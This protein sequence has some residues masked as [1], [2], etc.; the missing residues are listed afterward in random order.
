MI[1]RPDRAVFLLYLPFFAIVFA[2]ALYARLPADPA[3]YLW[4]DESWRAY[5]ILSTGDF[6][7][8]LRFMRED[9]HFPLFSEWLFG[10]IGLAIFGFDEFAFR[11]WPLIFSLLSIAGA[12][13]FLIR[14]GTVSGALAA[15]FFIS[16]GWGFIFHAREFKPFALD[17]ALTAWSFFAA[18][19][20][21][22]KPSP[23]RLALLAGTLLAASLCS[24]VFVFI[25]PAVLAYLPYR[26]RGLYRQREERFA[27]A[28]LLVP[29]CVFV[30]IYLLVYAGGATGPTR[31][32]WADFYLWPPENI[33]FILKAGVQSSMGYF[34]FAWPAVPICYVYCAIISWRRKDG[35]WLLLMTPLLFAAIASALRLYPLFGRPSFFLIGIGAMSVGYCFGH[36]VELVPVKFE[37]WWGRWGREAAGGVLSLGLILSYL[38]TGA[39]AEGI[40]KGRKWPSPQAEKVFSTL[41]EHYRPG[42]AVMFNYGAKYTFLIYRN[43]VFGKGHVS[44]LTHIQPATVLKGGLDDG[45]LLALCRSL[46]GNL[47]QIRQAKRV[48]FLTTYTWK[49]Y[50]RYQKVLSS[51]G[52]VETLVGEPRRGLIL[53]VPNPAAAELDCSRFEAKEGK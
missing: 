46:Q 4:A 31:G 30:A 5:A 33:P 42:D 25:Y 29:G 22:Q 13:A 7:E 45:T 41:A 19:Y 14:C 40:E 43:R 20:W 24:I 50:T 35:V 12:G 48:W 2:V 11:I 17:F 28:L 47:K 1:D 15:V 38:V 34:G 44:Q 49:A 3:P 23:G 27:L 6:S 16:V 51:L 18:V 36:V 26:Q 21:A 32:Y 9:R 8:F 10:N 52:D 37:G 39:A 53:L